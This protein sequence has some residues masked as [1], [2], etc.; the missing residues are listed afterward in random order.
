MSKPRQIS[1]S[2]LLSTLLATTC[3]ASENLG[4][5]GIDSTTIDDRFE[6][7]KTEVSNTATISGET[8]DEA[9]IENI[10]QVLNRIPGLTTEVTGGDKFKLHIRGVENQR[11][12]GEKPGVAVVID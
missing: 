8:V 5:I 10:Q 1:H 9:H 7:K 6:S 11:Y 12:M 3:F 4:T 2:I